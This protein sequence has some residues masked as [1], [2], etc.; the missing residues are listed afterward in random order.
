MDIFKLAKKNPKKLCSMLNICDIT[1]DEINELKD[2]KCILNFCYKS[3]SLFKKILELDFFDKNNLKYVPLCPAFNNSRLTLYLM[4]HKDYIKYMDQYDLSYMLL[5][6]NFKIIDSYIK[7]DFINQN[8]IKFN[9]EDCQC[10]KPILHVIAETQ[11]D[12]VLNSFVSSKFCTVEMM[13][14]LDDDGN[15]FVHNI[16]NSGQK[17]NIIKNPKF[18]RDLLLQDDSFSRDIFICIVDKHIDL[19]KDM[20]KLCPDAILEKTYDNSYEVSIFDIVINKFTYFKTFIDR[21]GFEILKNKTVNK[22]LYQEITEH[23]ILLSLRNPKILKYIL[24]NHFDDIVNIFDEDGQNFMF[25]VCSNMHAF[26]VF[27][28][29]D[30]FHVKYFSQTDKRGCLPID[31][32]IDSYKTFEHII[33]QP[34]FTKDLISDSILSDICHISSIKSFECLLDN[35]LFRTEMLYI[36]KDE[37]CLFSSISSYKMLKTFCESNIFNEK[38]IETQCD[39]MNIVTYSFLYC[40]DANVFKYILDQ[41][42]CTQKLVNQISE[43]FDTYIKNIDDVTSMRI[44]MNSKFMNNTFISSCKNLVSKSVKNKKVLKFLIKN[45]TKDMLQEKNDKEQNILMLVCKFNP[46]LISHIIKH[47]FFDN[48]MINDKDIN[49]FDCLDYVIKYNSTHVDTFIKYNKLFSKRIDEYMVNKTSL[50]INQKCLT[51]YIDL[52]K[53]IEEKCLICFDE[54]TDI[55]L[56]PCGHNMC[57]LCF[58]RINKCPYCRSIIKT[59]DIFQVKNVGSDIC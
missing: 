20:I 50:N 12:K 37:N 4:N 44:L 26:D 14:E 46:K 23:Y 30:K 22:S 56:K 47:K 25:D 21:F 42:W 35:G 24:Q 16:I 7:S 29:S 58:L 32:S 49:G 1:K 2:G 41:K 53:N 15:T 19:I 28:K 27:M 57:S 18:P 36:E 45:S 34:F 51:K 38:L 33:K 11:S 48:S 54:G 55:K 52:E 9:C 10:G 59:F 6:Q 13:M 8:K 3:F 5:S 17:P 40:I 39:D 31:V 43:N